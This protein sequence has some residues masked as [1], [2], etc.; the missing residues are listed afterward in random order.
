MV[1]F[2]QDNPLGNED[3]AVP[4]NWN[5]YAYYLNNFV[6]QCQLL[7]G[8]LLDG[9]SSEQSGH[10]Q[11][12]HEILKGE[13]PMRDEVCAVSDGSCYRL[14]RYCFWVVF[15]VVLQMSERGLM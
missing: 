5:H 11:R 4:E 12:A 6:Y 7:L 14:D 3:E 9:L 15:A 13:N 8:A 1:N 2:L 10:R